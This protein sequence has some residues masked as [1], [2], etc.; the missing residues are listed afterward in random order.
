M[1][2][3]EK[4]GAGLLL[5][6]AETLEQTCAEVMAWAEGPENIGPY[7]HE[8]FVANVHITAALGR[9]ARNLRARASDPSHD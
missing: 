6:L 4:E 2:D 9:L 1:T 7:Q 3:P 5:E 8:A